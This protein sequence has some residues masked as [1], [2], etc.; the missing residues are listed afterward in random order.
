MLDKV[1]FFGERRIGQRS[2]DVGKLG[3][4]QNRLLPVLRVQEKTEIVDVFFFLKGVVVHA[5][6]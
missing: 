2:A 1:L 3:L 5:T 4:A 6:L